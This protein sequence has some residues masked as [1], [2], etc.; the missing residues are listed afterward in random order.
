MD[1]HPRIVSLQR[2]KEEKETLTKVSATVFGTVQLDITRAS[3]RCCIEAA[4][5]ATR[6]A[7]TKSPAVTMV[8]EGV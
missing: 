5:T 4:E 6:R 1:H 7:V 2:T 8:N 3:W